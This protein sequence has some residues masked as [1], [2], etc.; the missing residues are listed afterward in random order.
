LLKFSYSKVTFFFSTPL[1]ICHIPI[2]IHGELNFS[3][4][5]PVLLFLASAWHV[6]GILCQESLPLRG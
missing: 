5:P 4:S 1:A 2:A 3:S 6:K